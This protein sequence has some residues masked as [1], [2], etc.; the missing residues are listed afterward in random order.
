MDERQSL[1]GPG[2]PREMPLRESGPATTLMGIA[3]G[4]VLTY[5]Q[6]MRGALVDLEQ[7]ARGMVRHVVGRGIERS[8]TVMF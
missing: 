5:T 4:P 3:A 1:S 6:R 2:E 7:R 8:E